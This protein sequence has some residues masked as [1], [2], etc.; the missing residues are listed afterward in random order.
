MFKNIIFLIITFFGIDKYFK[1]KFKFLPRIIVFHS[2]VDIKQTNDNIYIH[3]DLKDFSAQIEYLINNY[4][5]ISLEEVQ[6]SLLKQNRPPPNAV[7]IVVDDGFENFYT[8]IYQ[9]T[10]KLNIPVTLAISCDRIDNKKLPWDV[11][12][13]ILN[14]YKNNNNKDFNI[15]SKYFLEFNVVERK[16][17][18]ERVVSEL[19]YIS[20]DPFKIDKE[21]KGLSTKQIKELIKDNNVSIISHGLSHNPLNG[22]DEKDVTKELIESK[23][24]IEQLT[25]KNCN[26][27]VYPQG[28]YDKKVVKLVEKAGYNFAYTVDH[29]FVKHDDNKFLLKRINIPPSCTFEE[30]KVRISGSGIIFSKFLNYFRRTR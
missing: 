25:G 3:A 17:F 5:I 8:N 20:A 23:L 18:I 19:K 14:T 7:A 27:F 13:S 1:N 2:V 21:L 4:N 30:F 16:K 26:S 29:G 10:K 9:T 15:I 6:L 12:L 11:T 24:K 28:K 22:M